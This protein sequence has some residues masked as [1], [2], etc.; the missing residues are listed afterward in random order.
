VFCALLLSSVLVGIVGGLVVF[1]VGVFIVLPIAVLT[2]LFFGYPPYFLLRRLGWLRPWQLAL[3]GIVITFP[4]NFLINGNW[5]VAP[6]IA[7]LGAV[8]GLIFW[9]AGLSGSQEPPR[10]PGRPGAVV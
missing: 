8:A 6:S 3:A 9:W 7:A 10:A 5:Q 1:G 4:S 2:S